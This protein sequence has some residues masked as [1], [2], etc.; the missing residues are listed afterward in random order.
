MSTGIPGNAQVLASSLRAMVT[1][2]FEPMVDLVARLDT[3]T[4]TW[5]LTLDPDS[6][7]E[8]Q[9]WAMIDVLRVLTS[10]ADA[11]QYGTS[12]PRLRLVRG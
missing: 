7:P 4:S 2:S 9:C 11:A 8:D 12:V 3:T 6:P 10:G 5:V 1:V